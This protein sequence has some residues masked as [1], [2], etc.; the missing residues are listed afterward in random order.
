MLI[1]RRGDSIDQPSFKQFP[2]SVSFLGA[3]EAWR[4]LTAPVWL[5]ESLK[6]RDNYCREQQQK[7][8]IFESKTRKYP[9]QFRYATKM[10]E[11]RVGIKTN[12]KQ[13]VNKN[14]DVFG[15]WVKKCK[16]RSAHIV[17]RWEL[18]LVQ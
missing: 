7:A 1:L 6:T 10:S 4:L 8:T 9:V 13:K 11:L 3:G 18:S 2:G 12:Q 5:V 16:K 15:L 17:L 14:N